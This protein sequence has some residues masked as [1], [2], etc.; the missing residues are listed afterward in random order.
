MLRIASI[1][2]LVAALQACTFGPD[3]ELA[4]V[5][6]SNDPA[7]VEQTASVLATRFNEFRPSLFSYAELAI[8][9]SMLHF[10]FKNGAPEPK[11]LEYLYSTPGRVRAA[12]VSERF[13]KPWF[14]DGD[15]RDAHV[16]YQNSTR[17]LAIRLTPEAGQRLLQLTTDNVGEVVRTTLDGETLMEARILGVFGERFLI[18]GQE[19]EPGLDLALAVILTTGALPAEV[20]AKGVDEI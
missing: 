16:T 18:Q 1:V 4:L 12:L 17:A 3:T 13:G 7:V 8:E 20:R 14:T 9:G 15:I 5:V 6:D 10:T 2:V 19:L 11:V